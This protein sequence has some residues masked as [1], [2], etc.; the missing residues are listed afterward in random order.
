MS[1]YWDLYVAKFEDF[2]GLIIS[3]VITD[4]M[5]RGRI[6]IFSRLR[7]MSPGK[8]EKKRTEIDWGVNLLDHTNKCVDDTRDRIYI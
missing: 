3:P 5:M 8:P 1:F 2:H 7:K 6:V 4:D